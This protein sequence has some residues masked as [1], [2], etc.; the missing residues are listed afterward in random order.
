MAP[1]VL[2][3]QVIIV[4]C[5]FNSK[6]SSKQTRH[7]FQ[8]FVL[9]TDFLNPISKHE[10]VKESGL[11]TDETQLNDLNLGNPNAEDFFYDEEMALQYYE[12]AMSGST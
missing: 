4:F 1:V 7:I 8:L 9:F 10:A 5:S 2:P 6:K 11:L 3:I 12:L